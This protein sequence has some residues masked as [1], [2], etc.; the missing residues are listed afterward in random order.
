MGVKDPKCPN[1]L[2]EVIKKN[3]G[4]SSDFFKNKKEDQIKIENRIE[5]LESVDLQKGTFR[6]LLDQSI[7]FENT[8]LVFTWLVCG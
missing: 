6:N 4:K 5:F 3:E 1:C 2:L 8:D 7:D